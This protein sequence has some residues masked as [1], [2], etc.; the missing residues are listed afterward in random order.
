MEQ[1]DGATTREVRTTPGFGRRSLPRIGNNVPVEGTAP[2]PPTRT[3]VERAQTA[4][5]WRRDWHRDSRYD[6]RHWRDRHRSRFH[7]GIY[8]DPF[9]WSYR[10]YSIGWRLWPSYYSDDFWLNDPWY[11][12]LPPAHGPYRWIRYHGDALLVNIYTG[13]VVD[14]V[15][16]FFW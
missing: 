9:G 12:R 14:V 2:P 3:Q 15:Y 16:D 11:W 4:Q 6:W 8:W 1:S 7:F 13:E 5:H 10:R